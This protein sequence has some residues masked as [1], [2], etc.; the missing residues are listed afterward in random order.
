MANDRPVSAHDAKLISQGVVRHRQVVADRIL[1]NIYST[2]IT[3]A[4]SGEKLLVYILPGFTQ[5]AY[6]R[7]AVKDMV[8][9]GLILRNYKVLN[10][11][12][13]MYISWS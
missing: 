1:A 10:R 13:H 5:T 4:R 8:T 7:E 11:G 9:S 6:D 2:I 12:E 3:R